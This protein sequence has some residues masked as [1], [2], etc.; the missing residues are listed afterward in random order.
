MALLSNLMNVAVERG[1]LLAN[2]CKQVRRNKERPR[3]TA[4]EP[5]TLVAFL[6]WARKRPGQAQ[7]LAGMAEFAALAGNRRIEFRTLSWAQV[8]ETEVRLIRG[9]QRDGNVVVEV[10][11][12]SPAL[13]SLLD[14]MR[15]LAKDDRLGAVFPNQSGNAYTDSGFKGMWNKLVVAAV[16]EKAIETRFTFHDLRA[17]YV[18]QYKQQRGALPDLHANPGTTARIYDRSKTIN[19]AG[20]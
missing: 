7:V 5:A 6:E 13:Q 3:K 12:I 17:Y 15:A 19:R 2:P 14:R 9:K 20:L 8:G 11:A 16:A 10:V 4:P 1:D 18:T